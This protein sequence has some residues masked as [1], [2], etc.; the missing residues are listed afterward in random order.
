MSILPVLVFCLPIRHVTSSAESTIYS[1][2]F[3]K[4]EL[5]RDKPVLFST[6]GDG[7]KLEL[8]INLASKCS[9][10]IIGHAQ[11]KQYVAQWNLVMA[12]MNLYRQYVGRTE[13]THESYTPL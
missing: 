3:L 2:S 9:Y 7:H 5:L 12:V 1:Q 13:K 4:W 11:Q 10:E 6:V 8:M